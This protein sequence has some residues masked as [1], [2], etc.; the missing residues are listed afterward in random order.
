MLRILPGLRELS[1]L[2]VLP[3]LLVLWGLGRI[4][5][6][7]LS[8]RSAARHLAQLVEFALDGPLAEGKHND[9]NQVDNRD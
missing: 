4:L 1:R 8:T 2:R 5:G 3:G 6:W 7:E 9:N